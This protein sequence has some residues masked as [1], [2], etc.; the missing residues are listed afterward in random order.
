MSSKVDDTLYFSSY[1]DSIRT[2]SNSENTV[3]TYASGLNHF[4]KFNDQKYQCTISQV[5]TRIKSGDPEV[6]RLLSDFVVYLHKLG[7]KPTT[8]K[9]SIAAVKGLLRHEGIKIYNEDFK[10]RVKLPK[11]LRHM[12][13]PITKEIIVRLLRIVPPKLQT[14]ILVAIASGVRIGELVQLRISDINFESKPTEIHLR[15]ETTKTRQAREAFLTNEAT[16][17]LKDYLAGSFG[18]KEGESNQSIQNTVIFGRTRLGK[19][20]DDQEQFKTVL[21]AKGVLSTSLRK[22]AKKIPE[23]NKLNDNGRMMIHFHIFRS[24][25]RTI[26]GNAVSRDFAEALIGHR[27]YLDSYYQQSKEKRIELGLRHQHV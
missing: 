20:T 17:A 23:L 13:E 5:I 6:Y 3:R 25:C 10:Q 26:V 8:I 2:M 9:I 15:A 18:W 27:F 11:N 16:K 14:V 24:Y 21:S 4:T 19:K 7:R 22:Y 12:E 1:L